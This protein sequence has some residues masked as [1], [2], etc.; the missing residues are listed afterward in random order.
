MKDHRVPPP[1]LPRRIVPRGTFVFLQRQS[2]RHN[3]QGFK[4]LSLFHVE[5]TSQGCSGH[6]QNQDVCQIRHV[7]DVPRGT[8]PTIDFHLN[9][10]ARNRPPPGPRCNILYSS[11]RIVGEATLTTF[12]SVACVKGS[13][14]QISLNNRLPRESRTRSSKLAN[15]CGSVCPKTGRTINIEKSL[16][17]SCRYADIRYYSVSN[18]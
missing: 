1:F 4:Q 14:F 15:F 8:I 2:I 5:Q 16:L 7:R 18:Q 3:R 9:L 11:R 13:L 12:Y 17:F 10:I 6:W